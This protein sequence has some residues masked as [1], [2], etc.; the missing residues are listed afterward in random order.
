MKNTILTSNLLFLCFVLTIMCSCGAET[1]PVPGKTAANTP[2][3]TIT[4][5]K[6][7]KK[8]R[9]SSL[10]VE[11]MKT[12]KKSDINTAFHFG[13]AN[14][15]KL[16]FPSKEIIEIKDG[17]LTLKRGWAFDKLSK[18]AAKGVI[19]AVDNK[20]YFATKYGF[21]R[22]DVSK[23][24]KNKNYDYTGFEARIP[25]AKIG[26]GIHTISLV[27][28]DSNAKKYYTSKNKSF[29]INVK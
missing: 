8:D 5:P 3:K 4:K 6:P 20:Q 24:Y 29:K 11:R 19:V 25:T 18:K 1:K 28:V 9:L 15:K 10:N 27:I 22:P 14:G 21:Y 7:K 26:K 12:L 23:R 2:T 16:T 13:M 17:F